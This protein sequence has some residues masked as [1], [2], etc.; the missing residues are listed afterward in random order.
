M[1]HTPLVH[2]QLGSNPDLFFK[3]AAPAP[4]LPEDRYYPQGKKF[5]Y[6]FYSLGAWVNPETNN[7][8][9]MSEPEI[10]KSFQEYKAAGFDLFGPQYEMNARALED[11]AQH[12][13]NSVYTIKFPIN[14]H[15]KQLAVVNPEEVREHIMNEVKAVMDNSD[16][17]I[18]YLTP[19]E[20]RP[21]RKNEML[22]LETASKAIRDADTHKR[23]ILMYDPAHASANRLSSIAPWVDYLA[24]GMYTNYAS[25]RDSRIWVRWSMEQ[26]LEAIR[27]AN[28]Q[29]TPLAVPEMFSSR[30]QNLTDE[31][32]QLIPDWV[33]HDTY[34]SLVSGAK[35]VVVFSMRKRPSLPEP[36]W[37]AYRDANFQIASELMGDLNLSQVFL[38]GEP[39]DE[40]QIDVV[41][42]PDEVELLFP[43]G[44]VKDP[45]TY[46]SVNFLDVAYGDARYLFL[47]NS[48]NEA[49][50]VMA[51]GFPYDAAVAETLFDDRPSFNIAEGEF[52]IT[53]QPLEVKAYR[54]TRR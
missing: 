1:L 2:A 27:N 39:R 24:K 37:N 34:L 8:E 45:L 4:D 28:P 9:A 12:G 30:K 40:V 42:G 16:I 13:L 50:K 25:M 17:A 3:P 43:S 22:Y 46:S 5:I 26:E 10:Q 47:V 11:A 54:F 53:L 33:R 23:P 19:E 35:G 31:D 32:I 36:A 51:G 49:V 15:D 18:W 41:E 6:T 21:W 29:G 20:L 52:E 48:A 38:F 14:F 7:H 44:G